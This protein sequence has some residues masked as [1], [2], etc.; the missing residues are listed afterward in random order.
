MNWA[1]KF[2]FRWPLLQ[3][4]PSW[5]PG[6]LVTVSW[7]C[8]PGQGVNISFLFRCFDHLRV[9]IQF[10][11]FYRWQAE[12]K[13]NSPNLEIWEICPDFDSLWGIIKFK[14]NKGWDR[15]PTGLAGQAD[16][17]VLFRSD[18]ANYNIITPC[19]CN[20]AQHSVFPR[21]S[22]HQ[23]KSMKSFWR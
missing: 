20:D 13:I 1:T 15:W 22:R 9:L 14:I 16:K 4:A 17:W 19:S 8:G 7:E 12:S 2:Q 23:R 11:G 5:S 6:H 3:T 21:L 10:H 18:Q